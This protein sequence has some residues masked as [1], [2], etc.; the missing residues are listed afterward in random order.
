MGV[1]TAIM[2]LA[3]HPKEVP[4]AIEVF[5]KRKYLTWRDCGYGSYS[6]TLKI[7]LSQEIPVR[8]NDDF[9][10]KVRLEN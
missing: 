2:C 7:S 10:N 5:H 4:E 1:M 8:I 9:V 3:S 6:R